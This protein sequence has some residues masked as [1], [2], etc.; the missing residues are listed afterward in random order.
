MAE[1][2]TFHNLTPCNAGGL[3]GNRKHL[4]PLQRK[5]LTTLRQAGR[6]CWALDLPDRCTR[7]RRASLR[8]SLRSLEARGLVCLGFVTPE[9]RAD[10]QRGAKLAAWIPG[11][12]PPRNLR[13]TLH[14]A[15]VAAIVLEVVHQGLPVEERALRELRLPPEA[16]PY[17]HVTRE[18]LCRLE[19][20][21]HD[22]HARA[23]A[24]V[25][26][27]RAS[28]ALVA[29]GRLTCTTRL[30][31]AGREILTSLA[32][33]PEQQEAARPL[34]ADAAAGP[35]TR[36]AEALEGRAV[37]GGLELK[38]PQAQDAWRAPGERGQVGQVGDRLIDD[39]GDVSDASQPTD[40]ARDFRGLSDLGAA[41][42]AG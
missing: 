22:Y 27:L 9:L 20:P 14:G 18:T 40:H 4:G 2:S 10:A 16:T 21:D 24:R 30:D 36:R 1:R 13:E 11:M 32:P 31:R 35:G 42:G 34:R 19:V 17:S 28:R 6:W 38:A 29:S 39:Q 25:A 12:A 8:R 37:G 15:T 7:P 5:L 3:Q 26:I 33:G 23:R 41:R